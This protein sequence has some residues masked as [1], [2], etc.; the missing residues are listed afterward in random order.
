MKSMKKLTR[1]LKIKDISDDGSFSGYGSVFGNEDYY[2]EMVE[3]G[4]FAKSLKAKGP[5]GIKM[6]WQHRMD[7]PIG[8]YTTIEEDEKGLYVEGS[9]LI[10]DDPLA[11]RAWSHL[12]AGSLDGL[13]IGYHA[14]KT[15]YER[16]DDLLVLL[17][18][19]LW[20]VSV[21]TF[22]VNPEALVSDVKTLRQFETFLRD[23]GGFSRSQAMAIAKH[24]FTGLKTQ[25]DAR[26]TGDDVSDALT[27]L[28]DSLNV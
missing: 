16:E 8:Y 23:D 15:R 26:S 7:E 14:V 17:E 28:A 13:S 20:E 27:R 1:P 24:G 22:P 18:V 5:A 2:G 21:V 25:R 6:L 19:D 3:K 11:R 10:N 12:K 4:A 9:L